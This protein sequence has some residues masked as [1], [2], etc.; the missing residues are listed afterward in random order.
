MI[1]VKIS[2]SFIDLVVTAL[3]LTLFHISLLLRVDSFVLDC[4]IVLIIF[5]PW[6]LYPEDYFTACGMTYDTPSS[7]TIVFLFIIITSQEKT[8]NTPDTTE[9]YPLR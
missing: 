9:K 8:A 5:T 3:V 2:R 4:H 7:S 6:C 1:S